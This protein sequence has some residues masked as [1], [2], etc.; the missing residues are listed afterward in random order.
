MANK[1]QATDVPVED[2][3]AT[4][5]ER[6]VPEA[7][8]L[9][10]MM[11]DITGFEPHMYGPS[12][13]GFGS[14]RYRLESG[15][16]GDMP[17]LAFSPRKAQITIYFSEGFDRYGDQLARLGKHKVSVS[18]L[19]I[20][21]L[22]DV[23][24]AVLRSMLEDSY[25]VNTEPVAKPTNVAEYVAQVPA[26]ARPLFDEL[27]ELVRSVLPDAE[28]VLSYGIVGYKV[29]AKRARVF[30]SG[31]KDHVGVYPVP[32]DPELAA[33]MKPYVRGK[34]SMWFELDQ[35]LP[36]ELVTRIVVALTN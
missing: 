10:A 1:T 11:Q 9:I 7:R 27:R 30:I 19:Y 2:S 4:I 24:L 33:E 21:K 8:E 35:L 14:Q 29:D 23:D 26:A 3:L 15:R 13:I 20:T 34:G 5:P 17:R 32:K 36:R 12:I 22:S 31:W 6:R 25:A 18:C 28:E 16:E